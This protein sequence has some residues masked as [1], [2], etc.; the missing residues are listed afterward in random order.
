MK[1]RTSGKA[2]PRTAAEAAKTLRPGTGP[3]DTTAT[4]KPS[5]AAERSMSARTNAGRT[6]DNFPGRR[7]A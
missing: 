4:G 2:R 1:K 3:D 7:E 5:K 6:D